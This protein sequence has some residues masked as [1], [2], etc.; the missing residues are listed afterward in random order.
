NLHEQI[1]EKSH[2]DFYDYD[3]FS[4]IEHIGPGPSGETFRADWKSN[5]ITV[6]LKKSMGNIGTD[7]KSVIDKFIIL[8]KLQNVEVTTK[9]KSNDNISNN[10]KPR[11]RRV[12]SSSSGD[13]IPEIQISTTGKSKKLGTI[14][15]ELS[16]SVFNGRKPPHSRSNSFHESLSTPTTPTSP[17]NNKKIIENTDSVFL[18]DLLK[19]FAE[20]LEL[21]GDSTAMISNIKD[22]LHNRMR[23]HKS[24]F[25]TL[26][27]NKDNPQFAATS[28]Y[29][30]A[31]SK[32]DGLSKQRRPSSV[33]KVGAK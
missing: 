10:S 6:M 3:K 5:G 23:E 20:I 13:K 15:T 1:I 24:T 16:N 27:Q 25:K 30:L 18:K 8:E 9:K 21:S 33:L 11:I 22:Y 2:V 19:F 17:G 14:N 29:S 32:I 31:Q 4:E 28:G 7:D 12:S 26:N